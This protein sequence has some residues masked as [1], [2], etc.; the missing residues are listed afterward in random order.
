MMKYILTNHPPIIS[1]NYN[2][3]NNNTKHHPQIYNFKIRKTNSTHT[4]SE[5]VPPSTPSYKFSFH[6]LYR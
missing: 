1:K 6:Q 4:T 3:V 5:P 2:Q